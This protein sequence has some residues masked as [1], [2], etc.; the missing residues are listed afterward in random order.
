MNLLNLQPLKDTVEFPKFSSYVSTPTAPVCC[1]PPKLLK[2]FSNQVHHPVPYYHI[3]S[4][5]T[6]RKIMYEKLHT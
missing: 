3:F 1:L 2:D 6:E 5:A 4:G